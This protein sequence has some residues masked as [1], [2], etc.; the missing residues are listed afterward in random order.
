MLKWTLKMT[1]E[2]GAVAEEGFSLTP[3]QFPGLKKSKIL[4]LWYFF[5]K[6]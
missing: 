3:L 1:A 4:R 2:R 6:E 5:F